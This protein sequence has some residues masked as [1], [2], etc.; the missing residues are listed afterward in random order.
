MQ[1]LRGEKKHLLLF[2][3]FINHFQGLNQFSVR[4]ISKAGAQFVVEKLELL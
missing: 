4:S 1:K 2:L 3:I